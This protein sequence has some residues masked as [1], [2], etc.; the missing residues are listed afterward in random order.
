MSR[1]APAELRAMAGFRQACADEMD[2][3]RSRSAM[4]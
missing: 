4:S 3:N 1:P 2:R